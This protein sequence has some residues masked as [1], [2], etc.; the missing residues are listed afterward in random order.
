VDCRQELDTIIIFYGIS[1]LHCISQVSKNNCVFLKYEMSQR[2]FLAFYEDLQAHSCRKQGST[3]TLYSH[4]ATMT[5]IGFL[6]AADF[7]F[8]FIIDRQSFQ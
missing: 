6:G 7:T 1:Q 5:E 3:A 8:V 2:S 4:R